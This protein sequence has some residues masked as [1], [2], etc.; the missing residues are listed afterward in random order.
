MQVGECFHPLIKLLITLCYWPC[1]MKDIKIL[2]CIAL[3]CQFPIAK[4]TVFFLSSLFGDERCRRISYREWCINI[5]KTFQHLLEIFVLN[6][7]LNTL[8]KQSIVLQ[9]RQ[10]KIWNGGRRGKWGLMWKTG[11]WALD[12]EMIVG[13]GVQWMSRNFQKN[14]LNSNHKNTQ[15][16]Y[17]IV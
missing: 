3:L 1:F 16:Q 12:V 2:S 8:Y 6:M 5:F 14:Q 9:V 10:N 17:K 13:C 4:T 15:L 7:T 11:F